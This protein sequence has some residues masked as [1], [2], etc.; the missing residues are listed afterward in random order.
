MI[1]NFAVK[2]AEKLWGR[3]PSRCLPADIQFVARCKLRMLWNASVL[4]DLRIPP[5]SRLEALKGR[6]K[7]RHSMRI[8][9]Q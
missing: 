4:D 1:R 8:N 6:R 5:A 7:G 9:E 3:T 2:E